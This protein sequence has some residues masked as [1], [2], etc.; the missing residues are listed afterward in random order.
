MIREAIEKV[1]GGSS[2]SSDQ[3]AQAMDE[4]MSGVGK[5]ILRNFLAM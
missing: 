3:A 2:L 1:V 5:D 4:I